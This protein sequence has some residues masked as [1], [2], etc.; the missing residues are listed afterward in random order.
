MQS[1]KVFGLLIM[2]VEGLISVAPGFVTMSPDESIDATGS[3]S[4]MI[5][6]GKKDFCRWRYDD[7]WV[8]QKSGPS[9]KDELIPANITLVFN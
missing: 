4:S 9:S 3:A 1:D 5:G 8:A 6:G 2:V 7:W